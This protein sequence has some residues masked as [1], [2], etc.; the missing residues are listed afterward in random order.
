[1]STAATLIIAS[2]LAI[3]VL[4]RGCN[5]G[6]R[7]A[8]GGALLLFA[9]AAWLLGD[10]AVR[11]FTDNQPGSLTRGEWIMLLRWVHVA[12]WVTPF[13]TGL[14]LLRKARASGDSG[15]PS[16]IPD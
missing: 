6:G 1:M 11:V 5:R 9:P 12:V 16:P 10:A 14:L 15:S 7:L 8:A 4:A 3:L 2:I 13:A